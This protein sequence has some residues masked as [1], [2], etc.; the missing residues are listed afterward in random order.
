VYLDKGNADG[1]EAGDR[2]LVYEE[3][4]KRGFPRKAIGEVQVLIV[5]DHTSTAIVQKST[6]PMG[7]G[8]AVDFKK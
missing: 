8:N 7:R 2:F 1:V 3:P 6:E 5:K 4:N